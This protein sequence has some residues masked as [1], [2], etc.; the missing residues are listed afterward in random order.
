M[1]ALV[2]KSKG[3]I[4]YIDKEAPEL[5]EEHGVILKPIVVSPCTSDVHTIWYGSPKKEN[6]TFLQT[7]LKL[8]LEK[9]MI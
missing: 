8:M 5:K 6:L 2:L 3:V 7:N 1:K 9:I 4:E